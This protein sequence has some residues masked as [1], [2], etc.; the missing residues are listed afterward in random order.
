MSKIIATVKSV[1]VW[2]NEVPTEGSIW[3]TL[4]TILPGRKR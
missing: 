3:H 2:L 4:D 1:W